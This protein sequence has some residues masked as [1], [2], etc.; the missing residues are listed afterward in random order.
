MTALVAEQ[1]P[2]PHAGEV[3]VELEGGANID[4]RVSGSSTEP[5][6]LVPPARAATYRAM[7]LMQE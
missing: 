4:A 7:S 3:G 1:E 6:W 2:Q 5:C